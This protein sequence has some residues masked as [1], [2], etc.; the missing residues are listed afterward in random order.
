MSNKIDEW[1]AIL[2]LGDFNSGNV[3]Y[4]SEILSTID[5]FKFSRF[6]DGFKLNI[7]MNMDIS[8]FYDIMY[9]IENAKSIFKN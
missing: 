1:E 8:N 6:D 5:I 9:I 7:L 4:Y 2:K 3:Q